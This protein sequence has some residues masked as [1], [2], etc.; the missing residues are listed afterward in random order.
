MSSMYFASS[1]SNSSMRLL[2]YKSGL[3]NS[4]SCGVL[5]ETAQLFWTLL[6]EVRNCALAST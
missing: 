5:A 3:V 6:K 2:S 1:S 4:C